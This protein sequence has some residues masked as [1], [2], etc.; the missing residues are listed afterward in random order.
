MADNRDYVYGKWPNVEAFA[1][2]PWTTTRSSFA[3]YGM[4]G[5][6]HSSLAEGLLSWALKVICP[7]LKL[8][9]AL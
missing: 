9:K 5:L 1:V 7:G 4:K 6:V 2:I 3:S 8:L